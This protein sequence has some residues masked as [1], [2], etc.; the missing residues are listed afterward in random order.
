[1]SLFSDEEICAGCTH[2]V[3]HDCCKKFCHC[4]IEKNR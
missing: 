1:M 4:D 2:A 3:F